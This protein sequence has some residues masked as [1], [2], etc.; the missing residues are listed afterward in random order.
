MTKTPMK[1]Y[2]IIFVLNFTNFVGN[3]PA[4][5]ANSFTEYYYVKKSL[6]NDDQFQ[7]ELDYSSISKKCS[8]KVYRSYLQAKDLEKCVFQETKIRTVNHN[9]RH[10]Y[11]NSAIFEKCLQ[12]ISYENRRYRCDEQLDAFREKI[13]SNTPHRMPNKYK[14]ANYDE[15][16]E[17]YHRNILHN[18][19]RAKRELTS[20]MSDDCEIK[21]RQSF[22]CYRSELASLAASLESQKRNSLTTKN[23][24]AHQNMA[25]CDLVDNILNKCDQL[26]CNPSSHSGSNVETYNE[27]VRTVLP[28]FDVNKCAAF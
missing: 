7:Q 24:I 18:W 9:K 20:K 8:K 26:L 5:Y 28:E 6:V 4:T 10:D 14:A 19:S 16:L 27:Y 25:G 21:L 12:K 22:E 17:S 23:R 15:R 1:F 11:V 13:K 3:S 2:S